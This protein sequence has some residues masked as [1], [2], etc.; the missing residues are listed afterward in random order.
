MAIP[1]TK[2]KIGQSTAP[3]RTFGRARYGISASGP[4]VARR[5]MTDAW[6]TVN[7]RVAPSE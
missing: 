1:P 6:A 7:D 5:R 2:A 3:I 4:S